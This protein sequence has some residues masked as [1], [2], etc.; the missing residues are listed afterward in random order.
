MQETGTR[1]NP[2]FQD[3]GVSMNLILQ[4]NFA[5]FDMVAFGLSSQGAGVTNSSLLRLA[6]QPAHIY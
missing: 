3:E 1:W 6:S 5:P 4:Q 2:N